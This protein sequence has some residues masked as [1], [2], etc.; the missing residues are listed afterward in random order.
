M[1][2][3]LAIIDAIKTIRECARLGLREAK[4]MVDDADFDWFTLNNTGRDVR[5]LVAYFD[6]EV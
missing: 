3:A 6:V 5:C 4:R 1:F 2:E